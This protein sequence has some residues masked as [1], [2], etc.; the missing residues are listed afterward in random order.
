MRGTAYSPADA[1]TAAHLF[2]QFCNFE[3]L[4]DLG[5]GAELCR[6][7]S[8]G[9]MS[10][11]DGEVA[12]LDYLESFRKS[13]FFR[14]ILSAKEVYREFRFNTA[15][16]AAELTGDSEKAALLKKDGVDVI[17][18]GVIDIVFIDADGKLVLADYKTDRLTT[19]ELENKSA[20]AKK[21]WGR[22]KV[23][24][25]YYAKVCE[26]MFERAPDEVVI[27]SMPLG[28]TV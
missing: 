7:V 9:Y 24:L 21:L 11:A 20:A 22:H 1:G 17:A 6:L 19:Y 28:D 4:R 16:P 12:N 27:Y 18:Q 25:G 10:T 2:M 8:E 5:V 26:K 3:K 14:R 23:Q 15:V 13:D